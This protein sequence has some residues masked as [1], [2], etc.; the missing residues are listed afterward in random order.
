MR[1]RRV[2]VTAA[3]LAGLAV[4]G[5]FAVSPGGGGAA[6]PVPRAGAGAG[7]WSG[8]VGGPRAPVSAGQRVLVVL[9][10]FSLADRVARAGGRASD[11]DERRWTA[12]AFAAQQQFV[13]NLAR[14]G[15]AVRP[16]FRFTRTLNG[17][18]AVLDPG[19]IA[20][21]ERTPGVTGV[22]PVRAAFPASV[23]SQLLRGGVPAGAGPG[24]GLAGITGDGV[25]IALL[26]TG[27]ALGKAYLHGHVLEGVDVVGNGA[28]AT[29]QAMPTDPA[30]LE[31][32]GTEMAG[33][34]VGSGGPG[35]LGGV[36][37][38]ATVLPIRVAGWQSDQR[39]GYTVYARTDQ[40]LAGLE[41]AVDPN[42]DGDAHDAARIALIPLVEP[43]AAFTDGPL[44]R[45]AEGALRLDT[46]V[47]A[48]AGNDGPAGP[49]F[50]S[51]GGPAGAPAVV[52][53]GAVDGR[54]ATESVRVVARA[55]LGVF[56]DRVVPL[57]GAVAPAHTLLLSP[58]APSGSA[59]SAGDFLDHGLSRVAGRAAVVPAGADPADAARWA[60]EAGAAAV[61]LHGRDVAPGA[62]GL[63]ERIGIPVVTVPE[64][65]ARTLLARPGALVAIAAPRAVPGAG[66]RLAPFS[67]WGLAFDGG[68]KPELLAPGVGLVTAVPG[69][70][71]DGTPAFAT[72]SGSSAAAA[73]AAGAAA[74]LAE[75][76]P[77]ADAETLRGLLVG[78]ADA[79][80]ATP[81]PAQGTG[82]LDLGRSAA[83]E[84]VADPAAITFGNGSVDGWQGRAVLQL[85]NVSSRRLTLF[86]AT[87]QGPKARVLLEVSPRR[88]ELAPGGVGTVTVQTPPIAIV[89][90]DA[91]SGAL[92]ITPLGGVPIRVP[93]AVVL[94]PAAG[95]LGPLR[96]TRRSFAPSDRKPAVVFLRAGRLLPG[97]EGTAILPVLRLDVELWTAAGK[98]LGLVARLRDL[99]PGRYAFGLT[100]RGPGGKILA[101]GRYRVRIVAWPTGGGPPESRSVGFAIR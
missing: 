3:V 85:H 59:R 19:A 22:Y 33:L 47:V 67:S 9:N 82:L 62:L 86:V 7:S 10:A 100:G 24:I 75:A 56:L 99:L 37:P 101:S 96:L 35:G 89:H 44:A 16:E 80:P 38:G 54:P 72:V 36:A 43:F 92:T 64:P 95:L 40:L 90:A 23:S 84:L 73:V 70:N 13:S 48:A 15:I 41:R 74:L 45:A 49:A 12:A 2:A 30:E 27:V 29:P 60:A 31:Q 81:L 66:D 98:R 76:R 77:D 53:V 69:R 68:V 1:W 46:L 26:D 39:G 83:A 57:A 71:P 94:R 58:A 51:V 50:G 32:H 79:L 6:Q 11:S 8:L 52:A 20:L 63:D 91:A 28:G 87:G 17:F 14:K 18:S 97:A 93:W 5:L 88:L 78:G 4:G 34:L 21:L 42:G 61:L 65:A 25:T 55:G